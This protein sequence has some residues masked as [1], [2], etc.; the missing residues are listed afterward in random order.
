MWRFIG[1]SVIGSSHVQNNTDCQD[2]CV[3]EQVATANGNVLLAIVADG[4]GSALKGGQG[5][6]IACYS[7]S[8]FIIKQ[9]QTTASVDFSL[10]KLALLAAR[11]TLTQQAKANDLTLRDYAT[12]LLGVIITQQ[13][14][15]CFQIGDG[16][17]VLNTASSQGVVFWPDNGL[18]ANMTYFLTDEDYEQHLYL[19]EVNT[20]IQEAVLFTDGLQRL[21]LSF[22]SKTAHNPFFEPIFNALR[23][24]KATDFAVLT[25]HLAQF[26][27]SESVNKRTDDDKT[28]VLATRKL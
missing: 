28:L 1:T 11:T 3:I 17:I 6:A 5:A 23:Q 10:I 22:E 26:L 2:S 20:I 13:Q 27:A 16:A 4:A 15:W 24:A 19:Q 14:A 18:Y 8:Q 25:Q 21:A 7:A 9:L 12:T